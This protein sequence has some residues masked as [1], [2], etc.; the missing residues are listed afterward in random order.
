MSSFLAKMQ[1]D[2]QTY[3]VLEFNIHT[4]QDCDKSG[5]PVAVAR[6]KQLRVVIE[7]DKDT[8][9]FY[10]A[11]SNTQTKD[12]KITFHKRDALSRLKELTFKKAYCT[13]YEETFNSKGDHPMVTTLYIT[14][15]ETS[16]GTV[17]IK[18]DWGNLGGF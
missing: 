11:T 18:R 9:F 12:G 16:F 1:I 10:W 2:G 15:K 8:D 4:V 7:S 3:N 13:E 6:I 5:K 17:D 14:A